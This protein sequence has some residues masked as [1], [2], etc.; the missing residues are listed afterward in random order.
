MSYKLLFIA[1]HNK[2]YDDCV[3]KDFYFNLIFIMYK[4]FQ[5]KKLYK[6]V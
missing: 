2:S 3:Y 1:N 6:N 4:K 5:N